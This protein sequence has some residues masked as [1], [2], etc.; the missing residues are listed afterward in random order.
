[1][2]YEGMNKALIQNDVQHFIRTFSG[3]LS[4]LAFQGSPFPFITIQELL[5]QIDGYRRSEKK[6]PSWHATDNIIFPPKLNLEQTS[7][8]ITAKYKASLVSGNTLADLTGG[9]GVD[10]Y[11]FSKKFK[12]VFYFEQNEKLAELATHNFKTLKSNNI[13][14][15]HGNGLEAIRRRD[16]DVIYLDPA[17]R[18]DAKGKVFRLSDAEP[19]VTK[20]MSHL[21]D[22]CTTLLIK[23]SPMLDITEGLREL[24]LTNEVHVVAVQNEVKEVLWMV[25]DGTKNNPRVITVN[26][27]KKLPQ[28][29]TFEWDAPFSLEFS[30]PKNFIYE[31]NA[32]IMKSGGMNYLTKSYPL[33]K[34]GRN[35]HLFTSDVAMDFPGRVFRL[36]E[37][38]P[39]SKSGLSG[40]IKKKANITTRDFPLSVAQLRK[41][42]QIQDGGIH[43]LFF[44]TLKDGNKVCLVT[45][46]F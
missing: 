24:P 19:D 31:P 8:E 2:N 36:L 11:A 7:S 14:V 35:A 30:D 21:L 5:E 22:H 33:T 23:T 1:M 29:F 18:D 32:A 17:R 13:E 37:V 26:L 44:T 45:E 27:G 43:Y 6:L 39:Y 25:K 20:Y 10:S 15:F 41:K 46:K 40:Y 42:W 28:K 3:D 4:K 16:F 34:L 9:F 38:L 12:S